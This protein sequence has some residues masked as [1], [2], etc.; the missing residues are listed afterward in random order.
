MQLISYWANYLPLFLCGCNLKMVFK[1]EPRLRLRSPT[2]SF[3][4]AASLSLHPSCKWSRYPLRKEGE[5]ERISNYGLL[6][7]L[8][9]HSRSLS[10]SVCPLQIPSLGGADC[11][12]AVG[13]V[14]RYLHH[15]EEEDKRKKEGQFCVSPS[16]SR[17]HLDLV[18]PSPSLSPSLSHQGQKG[19]RRSPAR[20]CRNSHGFATMNECM[21]HIWSAMQKCPILK[22]Q[23]HVAT[24]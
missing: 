13:N 10:L 3:S 24:T 20:C 1:V 23:S 15:V 8:H 18:P 2:L 9:P 22:P 19:P 11:T 16:P 12:S 6:S 7:N 14:G 21:M 5:R 17:R 4:A